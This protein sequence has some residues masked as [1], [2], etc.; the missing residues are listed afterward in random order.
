MGRKGGRVWDE[1]EGKEGKMGQQK[2]GDRLLT[3]K[4]KEK[5]VEGRKGEDEK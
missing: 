1:K 3:V 4:R 5:G 2:E